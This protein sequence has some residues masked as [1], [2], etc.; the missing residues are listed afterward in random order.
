MS[1]REDRVSVLVDTMKSK[2]FLET[3]G[4][5]EVPSKGTIGISFNLT[6]APDGTKGSLKG[7]FV[8]EFKTSDDLVRSVA[9]LTEITRKGYGTITFTLEKDGIRE[10]LKIADKDGFVQIDKKDAFAILAWACGNKEVVS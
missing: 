6:G 8:K 1:K 7:G 5:K 4:V 3:L 9:E 10:S 2:K